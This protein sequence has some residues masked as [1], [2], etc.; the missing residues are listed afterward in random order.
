MSKL[1]GR[2]TLAEIDEALGQA[3]GNLAGVDVE[4]GNARAALAKLRAGE[5]GLH[6]ELRLLEIEQGE[7]LHA[8]DEADKKAE[9]VLEERRIAA[10]GLD[11]ELDAAEAA[12]VEIEEQRPKQQPVVAAASEALDA[13]EAEA[14]AALAA[15]AA[16]QAQLEATSEADFV[17]DQAEDKAAAAEADRV[18]KGKP[19]EADPLFAYLWRRGYG[20]SKYRAW[21]LTRWLDEKVARLA[22]YEPARRNYALLIE[23]PVRLA[24]HAAAMRAHFDREAEALAALEEAAAAEAGV[25][26]RRA[27]LESAEQD[28][29][30][31]DAAIAAREDTIRGLVDERRTFASGEDAFYQ[32]CVQILSEAMQ[33]K[34]IG[35]LRERAA[36]TLGR[37]DDAIVEKL[38][39]LDREADRIERNLDELRRLHDGESGRLRELEDVRRR[40]KAERFDDPLSEFIDGA[41][42]A[43]VLRQFLGGAARS[44]DVWD[45]IR[46]Q[47]RTRRVKADPGFGTLRFP[48]APKP[49]PWRMPKGGFGGRGGGFGGG[50][51]KTRGGFG[52]R[53]GGFKTRGKF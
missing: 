44:G 3:R 41:L 31:I 48:K 49:G 29:A 43:L 32:R 45:A 6:A 35:F 2:K 25:P 5:I 52:G 30:A 19:Y 24:E 9:R 47:Q 16:Y 13:A 38:A 21:P 20:T 14:Q 11:Q 15:D 7:L 23:I 40:F 1:S 34:S 53:S 26:E 42:I 28:L 12:L 22:D 36:R 46:R 50:G 8:L 33:R 51:F 10:T 17:A 27:E 4:F 39:E 18:E 37:E